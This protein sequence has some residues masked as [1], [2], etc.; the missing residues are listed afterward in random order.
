MADD[1]PAALPSF[2]PYLNST[3]TKRAKTARKEAKHSSC[4]V[5]SQFPIAM[6]EYAKEKNQSVNYMSLSTGD[7]LV[8]PWNVERVPA[9]D[10][11]PDNS[12]YTFEAE[13][14]DKSMTQLGYIDIADAVLT[15][16]STKRQTPIEVKSVVCPDS[17]TRNRPAK[18]HAPELVIRYPTIL[19]SLATIFR[20]D[21][22]AFRRKFAEQPRVLLDV[23]WSDHNEV[24]QYLPVL[25][26]F[27]KDWAVGVSKHQEPLV[28]INVWKRGGSGGSGGTNDLFVMSSAAF[29]YV[30]ADSCYDKPDGKKLHRIQRTLIWMYLLIRN[31]VDNGILDFEAISQRYPVNSGKDDKGL[32]LSGG[33]TK[34]Y[35]GKALNKFEFNVT[36]AQLNIDAIEPDQNFVQMISREYE[37]SHRLSLFNEYHALIGLPQFRDE[38]ALRDW[39][40]SCIDDRKKETH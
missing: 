20:N 40:K 14:D 32:S 34:K 35:F 5:N 1:L 3:N 30:V 11:F 18:Y 39:L 19:Q 10:L 31:V 16:P 7:A 22:D 6:L 26:N 24:I 33:I 13:C 17:A 25:R 4:Q 36:D 38:K 21:E 29:V 2:S 37:L 27:M 23:N 12:H 9:T 8:D 28:L 15:D